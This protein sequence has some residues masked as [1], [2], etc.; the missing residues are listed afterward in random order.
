I[1][2]RLV[3]LTGLLALAAC[4]S[5][6]HTEKQVAAITPAAPKLAIQA[7][8]TDGGA[9]VLF[10]HNEALPML[11][12]RLVMDA[13]SARDGQVAGLASMTSALLGEGA[14]GLSVDDIARGFENQGASFSSS[15]YRDMGV[16]SLRTLSD[17]QYRQPVTDLF[18]KVIGQPDFP[19]ASLDRIR[20]QMMQGLRMDQQ[21]P[22]PQVGK[23]F[24]ATLYGDHPYGHPSD[25]TLKSLPG[26]QRQQLVD[27]Y[28][29]YYAAGNAVIALVGDISR[30]QAETLANRISQAL[31]AGPAAPKLARA[32][33]LTERRVK[34]IDFPSSQTHILIGNQAT[35][36]GNPDHVALFV[37]NQILGGGGFASILTDEVRQKRGYV[38]GISSDFQPMAAGGPFTVQLQTANK[39]ADQALTLTLDLIRKFIKAGPT[40]EQLKE[41]KTNLLGS[42]ALATAD[43]GDIIGQLGAIGF[44]N[45][46]LDYLQQFNK[47]VQQVSADDIR[48]AFQHTLDPDHL[49]IVSIGPRAPRVLKTTQQGSNEKPGQ[50]Q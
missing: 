38:Y 12:V 1:M 28:Q 21:V 36:R 32:K 15:S 13:G 30:Q 10:V 11:D 16:I 27:F 4:S 19:Q 46:P 5:F 47:A 9:R 8:H 20:A 29:R 39:N 40:A 35:W 24:Q 48:R 34:H 17:P 50:H 44:Y 42:F 14:K 31:P 6:P 25:G 26:I 23:A 7:W 33:P 2:M 45:L 43:N 49:A 18:C 22:G 41:A 37:G 3:A